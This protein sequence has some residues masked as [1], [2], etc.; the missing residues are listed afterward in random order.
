M[1]LG[2]QEIR[3]DKN[4][5]EVNNTNTEEIMSEVKHSD[6]IAVNYFPISISHLNLAINSDQCCAQVLSNE[7]LNQTLSI[8]LMADDKNLR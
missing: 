7:I 1:D 8:F 4:E 3:E 2:N 5:K 6:I